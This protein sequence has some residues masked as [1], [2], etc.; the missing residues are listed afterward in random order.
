[1]A[2]HKRLKKKLRAWKRLPV[3]LIVVVGQGKAGKDV[4][5]AYMKRRY[6]ILHHYR[7][8]EAPAKIA[9][10]LGLSP[11]RAIL[12]KLFEV[13]ALLYPILGESAYKRRVAHLID[14][15]KPSL[16]IVEAI[17]TKEEYEEF[18]KKRKGVLIGV[19]APDGL[20]YERALAD[21]RRG[22]HEK[23]DEGKMTFKEFMARE[24]IPIERDIRWIVERADFVI[25]NRTNDYNSFY[26]KVDSIMHSLGMRPRSR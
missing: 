7:I 11:S 20:R 9:E 19:T 22:Y 26:K 18:A 15:E 3:R 1:M 5:V 13:N 10:V 25:E 8:A 2:L 17:R 4:S 12:Q 21:A 14:S 24:Q 23:R 16:A 6:R